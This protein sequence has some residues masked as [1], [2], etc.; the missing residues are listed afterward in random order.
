MDA[1]LTIS[2]FGPIRVLIDGKPVPHVR[3]RKALW[4]LALLV[5]RNGRP[6]AR[7]W[8]ARVLWPD[9]DASAALANLRTVASELRRAL[10]TQGERLR[11]S[12]RNAIA[13][14]IEGA[15]VD[16]L[17]FDA[18][19]RRGDSEGAVASY[20]GELLEGCPEE[21]VYQERNTRHEACLAA[22]QS[23]AEE[24]L[25]RDDAAG[26]A[27]FYRKA[28]TLDPLGDDPRRGLMKTL[29]ASGD[30]N[31][32]L[33]AYREFAHL[34]AEIGAAPD[35]ETTALYERL[36]TR[37]R[38]P[39][40]TVEAE[41]TKPTPNNLF[42]PLTEL[43][44]R[45]DERLDVAARLRR[46][47][48]VT[49]TGIGGV[50]K[51]RLALAVAADTLVEY[52]GGVWLVALDAL[53]DGQ[54]LPR[55]I[56]AAL[57]LREESGRPLLKSVAERLREGR[58]LLV[59]D[60]CEHLL[61]DVAPIVAGLLREC[62]DLRTL[63][64]SREAIDI[65]GETVW[66]V[67]TLAFPD[68]ASLPAGRAT[69]RQ[70]ALGYESVRL[71]VERARAV[72]P[73]F[74]LDDE[75]LASVVDVC[76][77]VEGLPLA[78]E[79]A[80]ACVRAMPVGTIAE[81]LRERHLETLGR[82]GRGV[83]ER[84]RT[85]RATLDWSYDLLT[86]P[87]RR[88]LEELSVFAGG[89]T[90]DAVERVAGE[91]DAASLV[92]ALVDKSLVV[93]EG[94]RGRYR[95]LEPVRQYASEK[96][97]DS[98]GADAAR[99]RHRVWCGELAQTAQP[100]LTGA[101]QKTWLERLDAEGPNLRAALA[102]GEND[103]DL[104]LR[105]AAALWRYWYVR[106][107]R[108]GRD[109]LGQALERAP[110]APPETRAA[111]LYGLG[112][113]AF[114]ESDFREARRW[115]EACLLLRERIGGPGDLART[116]GALGNCAAAV[117]DYA[118]ASAF[119]ERSIAILHELGD[120]AGV[121]QTTIKLA[122]IAFCQAHYDLT[123]RRYEESE[124]FFR[125]VGDLHSV[126]W[127]V[128]GLGFVADRKGE[129]PAAQTYGE[130]ALEIAR[131]IGDSQGVAWSLCHLGTIRR[132]QGQ[133]D[134]ALD[135]LRK[136][137]DLFRKTG[138]LR[139]TACCATILAQT[140]LDMGDAAG[141]RRLQEEGLRA[142]RESGDRVSTAEALRSL[143]QT[144]DALGEKRRAELCWAESLGIRAE[145]GEPKGM[146]EC[147]DTFAIL[148]FERDEDERAARLFGAAEA[149]RERIGA[150][151]PPQDRSAY[152]RARDLCRERVGAANFEPWVAE[153]RL[154]GESEAADYA[155]DEQKR[156]RP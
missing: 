7:E 72:R 69:R 39:G 88:L 80:A 150:P 1:P 118:D 98:G 54:A 130:E 142:L 126:L 119:C 27:A 32:A 117:D 71:F 12:G 154:L 153:G 23:L 112:C 41:G 105:T 48:L 14:D 101:D 46:S 155:L 2:L 143:G 122:T 144:L 59:L 84:Q 11:S 40:Q 115:L 148:A 102:Q 123:T 97:R 57:N 58:C 24:A 79:L 86:A 5:L 29:V 37:A 34:L 53:N 31:A 15:S 66:P 36:R 63:T 109:W 114:N 68:V 152:D 103:P 120:G 75:N 42:Q 141:A 8:V 131:Q 108:E 3:S 125:E 121:A 149:L 76:A 110:D 9:A 146:A 145:V 137:H 10:G 133:L 127:C 156:L 4:L 33:G 94:A 73:D 82:R 70:V 85:L 52:P 129:Y 74:S 19:I 61:D 62:A 95:L 64:T 47:R 26:A 55:A 13:L 113:L 60:N 132:H 21:W 128:L 99:A 140:M 50:G 30:A 83:E 18:A 147:L 25:E 136:S 104:A 16:V 106:S 17:T 45:E 35:A 78:L 89:W 91:E 93:L 124:A 43:V 77:Q 134:S 151:I 81:R 56:A 138:H 135:I 96:L 20:Q 111:A 100:E 65:P 28:V 107:M 90:P 116:L 139:A 51:T 92:G 22:L 67:P 38:R 44:G 6:A 87:E 49:L